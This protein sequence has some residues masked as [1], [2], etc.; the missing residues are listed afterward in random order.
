MPSRVEKWTITAKETEP[1]IP[2]RA[3]E[4]NIVVEPL[5]EKKKKEIRLDQIKVTLSGEMR[6]KA[7]RDF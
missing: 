7:E 4:Q 6:R 1:N 2:V 5:I 3:I